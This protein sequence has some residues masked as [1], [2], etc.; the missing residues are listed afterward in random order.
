MPPQEPPSYFSRPRAVSPQP[1]SR[2]PNSKLNPDSRAQKGV[3]EA[4]GSSPTHRLL[5]PLAV[6]HLSRLYTALTP[7][8]APSP[9]FPPTPPPLLSPHASPSPTSPTPL[10]SPVG[11]GGHLAQPRRAPARGKKQPQSPAFPPPIPS[12][13]PPRQ[14]TS[15]QG[16]LAAVGEGDVFTRTRRRGWSSSTRAFRRPRNQKRKAEPP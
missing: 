4:S 10:C 13:P 5:S 7:T 2:P 6:P 9:S 15:P 8:S 1:R 14:P 16:R 3:G 12:S 11:G